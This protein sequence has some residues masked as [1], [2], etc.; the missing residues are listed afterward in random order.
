MQPKNYFNEENEPLLRLIRQ[1]EHQ[2]L[3]FKLEIDDARK[4][5]RAMAAFA[6]TD[7][8]RL[9]IGVK[10][11]GS[12][13][14]IRSEEEL[15]MLQAAAEYYTKP[16]IKYTVKLWKVNKKTVLEA[17]IPTSNKRPHFVQ[18]EKNE[19]RAYTRI[20]DQNVVMDAIAVNIL[21]KIQHHKTIKIHFGKDETNV[22]MAMKNK[23]W[24]NIH[25]IA[26][27]TLLP[28][29]IVQQILIN[30]VLLNVITY[31]IT[32]DGTYFQID[33]NVNF[34]QYFYHTH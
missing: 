6:N 3:D 7:G 19:W 23:S 17:Y 15:Y 10:D 27:E 28:N 32:I 29:Q 16:K 30:F 13:A 5:A 22:L 2:Q 14:G 9:L 25:D 11:N 18:N 8:G 12:I 20:N 26:F 31:K 4:I 24:V 1:G 21:K 33:K 34:D